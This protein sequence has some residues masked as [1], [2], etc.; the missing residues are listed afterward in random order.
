MGKTHVH[1]HNLF[2]SVLI[3]C[4]EVW[5]HF[6]K[7]NASHVEFTMEEELESRDPESGDLL[8]ICAA[9]NAAKAA[10]IVIGGMA[11]VAHG[12]NRGTEDIDLLVDRTA[13]NIQKLREALSI[14]P[15]NAISEVRD[16]DIEEYGVVR[17][18]DEVVVDLMGAA[19]GIDFQSAKDRV[20]WKEFEGVRIPFATPELLLET[21]QTVREKDAIDRLYLKRIL[22]E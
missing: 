13:E 19:C 15:D 3:V 8:R 20:V 11:M 17:V 7:D 5:R 18:A 9:L 14:L 4:R 12:F 10:Y 16:S 2:G 22:S 21:K 6:E 1:L